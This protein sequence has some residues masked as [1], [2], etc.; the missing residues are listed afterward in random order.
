VFAFSIHT[1]FIATGHAEFTLPVSL[2]I[3]G[4]TLLVSLA[5]IWDALLQQKVAR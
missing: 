1:F 2:L 5:Q 3:L 4:A